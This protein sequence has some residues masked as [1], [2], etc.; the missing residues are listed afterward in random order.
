[1]LIVFLTFIGMGITDNPMVMG[2]MTILGFIV[3]VIF[4][5]IYVESLVG[6]GGM[7]LWLIILVIMIFIKGG[8]R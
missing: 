1:M 7:L 2:F 3:L 4:N 8:K 5:L 6:K